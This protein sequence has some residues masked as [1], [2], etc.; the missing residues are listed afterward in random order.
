M[1]YRERRYYLVRLNDGMSPFWWVKGH[2]N[3]GV[4]YDSYLKYFK[5]NIKS[6]KVS[7]PYNHIKTNPSNSKWD[8]DISEIGYVQMLF[9]CRKYD[10][11]KI[12]YIFGEISKHDN[13][14]RYVELTKEICGQ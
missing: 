6:L 14:F 4:R 3:H 2:D 12:E 11:C 13:Y 5:D 8:G 7:P 1:D 10:V 9:S